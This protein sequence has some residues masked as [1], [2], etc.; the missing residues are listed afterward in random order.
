MMILLTCNT[1]LLDAT[2]KPSFMILELC[3]SAACFSIYLQSDMTF[4]AEDWTLS[5]RYMSG[6]PDL[7]WWRL[8]MIPP[9]LAISVTHKRSNQPSMRNLGQETHDWMWWFFSRPSFR[10][11]PTLIGP[12][13]QYLQ[14]CISTNEQRPVCGI[15]VS[16]VNRHPNDNLQTFPVLIL[17]LLD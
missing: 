10:V 17:I 5:A 9:S 4:S 12:A 16:S 8:L 14:H 1:V 6:S 13:S 11:P 15:M 2:A 7:Y 3:V